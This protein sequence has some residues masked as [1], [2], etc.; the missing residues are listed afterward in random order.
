MLFYSGS[1]IQ[2]SYFCRTCK[3]TENRSWYRL[4][5]SLHNN[6]NRPSLTSGAAAEERQEVSSK[7]P[8]DE[9]PDAITGDNDIGL[10]ASTIP[11]KMR[12][13]WLKNEKLFL[14]HDVPQ[15]RKDKNSSRKCITNLIRHQNHNAEVIER[16]WLCFSPS[17]T[18]IYCLTCRL[19]WRLV[20]VVKF[21]AEPGLTFRDDENVGSP[22]NFFQ[23]KFQKK[24]TRRFWWLVLQQFHKSLIIVNYHVVSQ[25]FVTLELTN[26]TLQHYVISIN[27]RWKY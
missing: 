6:D 26:V 22:R 27:G 12:E 4:R 13:H 15:H 19:T 21:I 9:L 17:Q 18:C 25:S 8:M 11:E 24:E 14:K 5:S 2:R 10:L 20:S 23:A 1:E 3:R 7:N 16:S